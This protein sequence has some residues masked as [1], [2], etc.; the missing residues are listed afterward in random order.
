MLSLFGG[1]KAYDPV[2]KEGD[3]LIRRID[4]VPRLVAALAKSFMNDKMERVNIENYWL[5]TGSSNDA[6]D[7][8]RFGRTIGFYSSRRDVLDRIVDTTA[9]TYPAIAV[10]PRTKD[11]GIRLVFSPNESETGFM[12]E[13]STFI[14]N[15]GHLIFDRPFAANLNPEF[16]KQLMQAIGKNLEK[17]T[18][19]DLYNFV[20]NHPQKLEVVYSNGN[21]TPHGSDKIITIPASMTIINTIGTQHS[22]YPLR[23]FLEQMKENKYANG[24]LIGDGHIHEA[25]TSKRIGGDLWL[26]KLAQ[27][28][29]PVKAAATLSLFDV[30][31]VLQMENIG[32]YFDI[33]WVQHAARELFVIDDDGDLKAH[34]VVNISAIMKDDQRLNRF[35]DVS[36]TALSAPSNADYRLK[37]HDMMQE[38]TTQKGINEPLTQRDFV[39]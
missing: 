19:D 8:A 17:I 4:E 24:E 12:D 27:R 38:F 36:K 37:W 6:I 16:Q 18:H 28:Y 39:M 33:S 26:Q 9:R 22:Y 7:Q 32:P 31:T 29:G 14:S 23:S 35:V 20:L 13:R 30:D 10:N 21:G 15:R 11:V 2:F 5:Y 1:T 3:S 34:S 25:L